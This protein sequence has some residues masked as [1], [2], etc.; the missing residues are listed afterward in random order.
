MMAATPKAFTPIDGSVCV[1][2][3]LAN[4]RKSAA[5]L[6]RAREGQSRHLTRP[7]SIHLHIQT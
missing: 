6:M 7:K 4:E 5:A 2:R 3:R 1:E